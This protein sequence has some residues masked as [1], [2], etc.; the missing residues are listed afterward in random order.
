M[1]TSVKSRL[2]LIALLVVTFP[3]A[4]AIETTIRV[5][6]SSEEVDEVTFDPARTPREDVVRWLQLAEHG[7]YDQVPAGD[8][9]A[10]DPHHRECED[11]FEKQSADQREA[12]PEK[13]EVEELRRNVSELDEASTPRNYRRWSTI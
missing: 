8:V 10:G 3:T 11:D 6:L 7:P 2:R 4:P 1:T 12:R 13:V 9:C 5:P